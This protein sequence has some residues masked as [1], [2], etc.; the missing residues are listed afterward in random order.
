MKASLYQSRYKITKEQY[1]QMLEQQNYRCA[2]C[3]QIEALRSKS[4][5]IKAL[6]VDHDHKTGMVR[7]LLCNKCNKGLGLFHDDS[8]LLMNA[9][10]YLNNNS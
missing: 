3:L 1:N 5:N 4:G 6:V 8:M 2:I 9:Y 7:G 10:S